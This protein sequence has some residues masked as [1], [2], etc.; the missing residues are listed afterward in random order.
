MTSFRF[1]LLALAAF[2]FTPAAWSQNTGSL[3]GQVTDPSAAVIP[4][5][6]VTATGPGNKVKVGSTNQ[7]GSYVINGLAPGTYKV[8]VMAKGFGVFETS[9]EVRS[10]VPQTVDASLAVSVDKQEV[11]VTEQARV[12]VDPSNNGGALILKG[13]DLDILSDDPDDL[14]SDLQALA[15]PG[16]GPNGGQIYIDRLTGRRA[17]PHTNNLAGRVNP[18]T[19]LSPH[20]QAG[21]FLLLNL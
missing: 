4:G 15:G 12:D 5:A 6:S 9:V 17:P 8:R 3:R 7:Q 13:A 18:K 1:G 19:V 14:A 2:V 16:A 21:A 20:P 11:T 10:G